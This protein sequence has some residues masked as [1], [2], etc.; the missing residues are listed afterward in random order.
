MTVDT[1][2]GDPESPTLGF[3][4]IP[5]GD[6]ARGGVVICPPL[7]HEQVIAYRAM[8]LLGQELAD[9]GLAALRFD[10]VGEGD[11]S[12]ASAAPDAVERWL[13]TIESAVGYLRA[14]GVDQVALVGLTSGGLL[15]AEALGRLTGVTGLVL[16]DPTLSGRRFL[17]RQ[18]SIHEMTVGS[19]DMVTDERVPLLS[20]TLHPTAA[21]WLEGAEITG[22]TLASS[23][24]ATL[25]LGRRADAENSATVKLLAALPPTVDYRAIDG[26]EDLLDVASSIAV[27]PADTIDTV[28]DWLSGRFA[29]AASRVAPT[30]TTVATVG[31]A[32][33][34]T[35]IIERLGRFGAERIFTIETV[36]DDAV[37]HPDRGVVVM[38]PAAAEH[39]IGPGRFQVTAA[40]ELAARGYRAVRFDRRISG[41]TTEVVATEPNMV[42]AQEWIDDGAALAAATAQGAPLALVGLCSGAWVSARIAEQTAARLTVLLD[43]NYYRTKPYQPGHYASLARLDQHGEPQ[44]STFR[45]RL[46]DIIPG[47]L[48]R[49]VSRTQVFNDPTLLLTPPSSVPGSTVALLL[50]PEDDAVLVKNRGADAVRRLR[51]AGADIRVTSYDFGDHALF[52][53]GVRRAM[54][55]DIIDLVEDSIP[56]VPSPALRS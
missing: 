24:V 10:Y 31:V 38:Q 44:L 47:W 43:I 1:W 15:A 8:R 46:R 37:P 4:H 14:S 35:R 55:H 40:R 28:A 7:G 6:H 17:R 13:A 5:E 2:F 53:E 34:G 32:A 22:A 52:G 36:L 16:W 50:S 33:D 51:S 11:A 39:R 41:E 49:L 42:L 20:L 56:P 18:K 3:L 30:V 12:G 21:R 26:Q 45:S 19:D 54:L 23:D 48:W 25:L 27:I 9:R 29:T